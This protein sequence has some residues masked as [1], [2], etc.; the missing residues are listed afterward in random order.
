MLARVRQENG[1]G[2]SFQL[3]EWKHTSAVAMHRIQREYLGRHSILIE[4]M[5]KT[6]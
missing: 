2:A 6:S 3:N 4:L 5:F 1:H